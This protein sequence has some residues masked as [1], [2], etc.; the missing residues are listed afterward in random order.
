MDALSKPRDCAGAKGQGRPE[1]FGG[2]SHDPWK[3]AT[4]MENDQIHQH[5][6]VL[7]EADDYIDCD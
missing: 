2:N 1:R 3:G 6:I 7:L 5:S 4:T